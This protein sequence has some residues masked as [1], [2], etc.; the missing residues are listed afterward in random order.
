M[1][2]L[3]KMANKY[4]LYKL[5]FILN[6]FINGFADNLSTARIYALE[7]NEGLDQLMSA[8][9]DPFTGF[10]AK[11]IV[12]MFLPFD[13][14]SLIPSYVPIGEHCY[15]MYEPWVYKQFLEQSLISR[16]TKH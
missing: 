3:L 16:M 8:S 14:I 13:K 2:I 10:C 5:E 7:I 6:T 12:D 11:I 9:S 4:A 15:P 1:R